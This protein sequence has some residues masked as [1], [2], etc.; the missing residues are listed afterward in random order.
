MIR[1]VKIS[2][3]IVFYVRYSASRQPPNITGDSSKRQY[4]RGSYVVIFK[5]TETGRDVEIL[6]NDLEF[7]YKAFKLASRA[8]WRPLTAYFNK[9]DLYFDLIFLVSS[10]N[11]YRL[12]R[13]GP[14]IKVWIVA[15]QS[16]KPICYVI[17]NYIFNF[18]E[19]P[20]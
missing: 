6:L 10:K 15:H 8:F 17:F 16:I 7:I 3:H 5:V 13:S 4:W 18:H 11:L 1:L 9:M 12:Y 14:S 2:G 20:Y 19:S